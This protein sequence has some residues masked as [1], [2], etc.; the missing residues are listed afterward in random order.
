MNRRKRNPGI[1]EA[2]V[3]KLA[4]R[5]LAFWEQLDELGLDETPN[6]NHLSN[7]L[8]FLELCNFVAREI[9]TDDTVNFFINAD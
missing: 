1:T 3:D 2:Q 6:F 5:L 9:S 7:F 4:T 8:S